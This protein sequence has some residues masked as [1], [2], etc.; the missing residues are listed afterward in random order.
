MKKFLVRMVI[1]FCSFIVI[2][3]GV[4]FVGFNSSQKSFWGAIREDSTPPL[5]G[6]NKPQHDPQKP[7]VAILLGNEITEGLD[8]TIPFEMFSRTGAFNVYAVAADNK[9]KSLSGGVD[10][11]PHYTF[12][13][14]DELLGKKSPD[15]ITIPYITMYR[16]GSYE[17]LRQWILQHSNTTFLSI[18]AGSGN[19]AA[20]G[21]LDGKSAATHW[22]TYSALT[23]QYP[24]VDW[25]N[26]QRY[27]ISDKNIVSSAGISSGIDAVLYMISQ[28][29]G[30]PAAEKVAKDLKYPSYHFLKNPT[31]EPFNMDWKF[32]TYL[33]NNAFQWSKKKIGA[34]LY[35]GMEEMALA[36]VFD[37]YSD[38]GTT[39]VFSF[40]NSG[41][42]I[43]TKHGLTL[44]P[45]Y[46]TSNVPKLDKM[47]VPGTEAKTLVMETLR[48]WE[49]KDIA[50]E[51]QFVH[52]DSIDKFIF[53]V[54]LEDL[55]KQEDIETARHAVK[56]LEYRADDVQLE[57]KAFPYETYGNLL[58]TIMIAMLVAMF[59]D[60]RVSKINKATPLNKTV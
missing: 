34:M 56:R 57:G 51:F 14:L 47:I 16:K 10:I 35:N 44:V 31:V 30:E 13:E 20:T 9:V 23:R 36:S 50:K 54:Q 26:G 46:T 5:E 58:L 43:V 27:V 4:G 59:L 52:S 15:I 17:P 24:N 55:A 18:C 45:R 19:L 41:A 3:G 25:V 7:T 21:L 42:P 22:Q 38:S 33:L 32:S 11:V 40:S 29:L 8:F 48:D 49:E 60:R 53:E 6:L 12:K 37:I 39:K 1:Y 28:K 2:V